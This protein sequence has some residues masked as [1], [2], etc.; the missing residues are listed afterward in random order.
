MSDTN[1]RTS[2][3]RILNILEEVLIDPDNFTAKKIS[4]KLEIPLATVYRHIETLCDE[5]FLIASSNKKYIP[6]PKIRSI[7][8]HSLPYEPN[9]TL[10]RSYLRKLTADIKETVSL[11]VPIGTKLVYFDRI[12]FHWPMQLNLEAGDHLPLHASASGKLYL[13]SI[14]KE[15][16]LQIFNNIKTPTSAK[17][18]ITE[19]SQFKKELSKIKKQGYAFDDEEWFNGMVGLSL[20]ITNSNNELCFCLSTHTA[21]SRKNIDGLKKIL[22]L[23]LSAAANL[24]KALFKD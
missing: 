22:P 3:R 23:M 21:K 10:R 20:P 14:K 6:G 8:L 7:I 12:E 11:S 19:I 2:P 4:H 5:R 24:K 16:A 1:N 9:F 15:D 18:T 13:S 17:N